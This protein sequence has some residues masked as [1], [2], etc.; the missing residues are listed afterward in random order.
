MG[1]LV[2]ERTEEARWVVFR[3]LPAIDVGFLWM[4][5]PGLAASLLY[6]SVDKSEGKLKR[7]RPKQIFETDGL[8][9]NSLAANNAMG[10]PIFCQKL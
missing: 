10:R 5:Q 4:P 3:T 6:I 9:G 1:W 2:R 8:L 7:A